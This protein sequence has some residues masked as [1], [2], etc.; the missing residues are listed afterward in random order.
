M[1][2]QAVK[3]YRIDII[4][5][6]DIRLS[7]IHRLVYT[8]HQ[9]RRQ[10]DVNL[11]AFSAM[12]EKLAARNAEVVVKDDY[13]EQYRNFRYAKVEGSADAFSVTYEREFGNP[14]ISD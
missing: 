8:R 6:P 13:Y 1:E 2:S 9:R 3:S 4:A 14:S 10:Y 11:I 5:G 7:R 12:L